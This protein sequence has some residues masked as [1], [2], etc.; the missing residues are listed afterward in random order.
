M[1]FSD[2]RREYIERRRLLQDRLETSLRRARQ[3]AMKLE[4]AQDRTMDLIRRQRRLAES[5]GLSTA[6]DEKSASG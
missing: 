3:L 4:A 1:P 5:A 6:T 2:T